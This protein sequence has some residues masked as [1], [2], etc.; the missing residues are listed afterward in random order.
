MLSGVAALTSS[1]SCLLALSLSFLPSRV[2]TAGEVFGE[3]QAGEFAFELAGL[4]VAGAGGFDLVV[5]RAEIVRFAFVLDPRLSPVAVRIDGLEPRLSAARALVVLVLFRGA[6][7][8]V[9]AEV[10]E[11]V[12]I[13][14][15]DDHAGRSLH[16]LA[17]HEDRAV[18]RVAAGMDRAPAAE[19]GLPA[20]LVEPLVVLHVYSGTAPDGKPLRPKE[21]T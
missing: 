5:E 15:I 7:A 13:H 14:V 17:V 12:S 10:V 3:V 8:H 18:L 6:V 19:G 16:D 9:L 1:W 4:A 11:A 20:V 2:A 21:N